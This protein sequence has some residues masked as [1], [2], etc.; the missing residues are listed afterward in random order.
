MK[1]ELILLC[2]LSIITFTINE[3]TNECSS[4]DNPSSKEQCTNI[5]LLDSE[6]CYV[7]SKF[8][9][10]TLNI[11]NP[12]NLNEI[13]NDLFIKK[14]LKDYKLSIITTYL[15]EYEDKESIDDALIKE[16][17]EDMNYT[18]KI[19]CKALTRTIDF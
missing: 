1:L 7:E 3:D 8:N 10:F 13:N 16:L 5:N 2:L 4:F 11:C 12:Y 14:M 18:T 9:S 15:D 17:N 19:E 6:C